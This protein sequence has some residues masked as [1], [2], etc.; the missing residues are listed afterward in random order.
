MSMGMWSYFNL[1]C[2][3]LEPAISGVSHPL[4]D[5]FSFS[6]C[7]CVLVAG[8]QKVA[9]K[10]GISHAPAMVGWDFHSG[11]CCPV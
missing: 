11:H 4:C 3:H 7:V 8:I 5:T 10:L 1:Q 6:V 2:Y 9:R